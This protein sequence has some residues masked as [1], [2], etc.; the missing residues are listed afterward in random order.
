MHDRVAETVIIKGWS[1]ALFVLM[2]HGRT[3]VRDDS[4]IS[5]YVSVQRRMTRTGCARR[6]SA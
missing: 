1:L 3:D 6:L 2:T 5:A 4:E